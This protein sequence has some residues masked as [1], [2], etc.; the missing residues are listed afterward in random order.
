[1]STYTAERSL[2]M[3]DDSQISQEQNESLSRHSVA[4]ETR[5]LM[6]LNIHA[7]DFLNAFEILKESNEALSARLTGASATASTTKA[8]GAHPSMGVEIVCLAF[9]VELH[10]KALHYTLTGKPPRGHNIL[11][12]FKGLPES[13]QGDTFRHLSIAQYGWT[14]SEFESRL[15]AIS[16]GFEKW[17]YA[18]ESTTL[19][20]EISFALALIEATK[21]VATSTRQHSTPEES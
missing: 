2:Q 17:R 21:A 1:M 19:R 15:Q 8:F 5:V 11:T 4:I 9:S 20:Y 14:F 16:G 13:A 7:G 3:G 18:Y 12:L 6:Y 10:I